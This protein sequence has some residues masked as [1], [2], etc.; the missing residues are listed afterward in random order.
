MSNDATH[1]RGLDG[2]RG[3]AV[4]AVLLFH[5]R[6]EPFS[7]GFLGVSAFFTLSGYLVGS[8]LLA[9]ARSSASTSGGP[10]ASASPGRISLSRFA[11]RRLR[12]LIPAALVAVVL[13]AIVGRALG[14]PVGVSDLRWQAFSS[15][16]GWTN[17]RFL[18]EGKSYAQLFSTP[19][20]FDHFWSL[21]IEVQCY[22]IVAVVVA[23][24]ARFGK[25]RRT[26]SAVALLGVV[27]STAAAVLLFRSGA[28]NARVY[29]GTDTRIAEFLVGVALA[30]ALAPT[31]RRASVKA[32]RWQLDAAGV[33]GVVGLLG[34]WA[35]GTLTSTWVY[36]GGFTLDALVCAVIIYAVVRR[37]PVTSAILGVEPLAWLGRLSYGIYLYHWPVFLVLTPV[38]TG[39]GRPVTVAVAVAVT[40]VMA[41]ASAHWIEG[42]IRRGRIPRGTAKWWRSAPI[43]IAVAMAVVLLLSVVV[44]NNPATAIAGPVRTTGPTGLV[45]APTGAGDDGVFTV[46]AVTDTDGQPEV[47]ALT[48]WAATRPI[49][50][51]DGESWGCPPTA[52][53]AECGTW[54]T[55]WP[56]LVKRTKADLVVMIVSTAEST[57]IAT[58]LGA[59]PPMNDTATRWLTERLAAA[60]KALTKSGTS[61][62][63]LPMPSSDGSDL[64]RR[65][66]LIQGA[67]Y[68]AMTAVFSGSDPSVRSLDVVE[69]YRQQVRAGLDP[70][71]RD[72]A[73]AELAGP[74]LVAIAQSSIAGVRRVMV[75][76]DSVA[77]SVG[78]GLEAW[79][80]DRTDTAVW[81]V[82][83]DGCGV[84]AD[85]DIQSLYAG[86]GPL[87][88]NCLEALAR[89]PRDVADFRPDVVVVLSTIWDLADR[90]LP[91]WGRLRSPGDELFDA[92]MANRYDNTVTQLSAT[93]AH[94]VWL[95]VP[96]TDP[97]A[98]GLPFGV[99]RSKSAFDPR[100]TAHVNATVL[101]ELAAA[102]PDTVRV[103]DLFSI[104][105]PGGKFTSILGGVT[106]ARPDGLHFS[107]AGSR[108]LAD[109]HAADWLGVTP[110]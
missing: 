106:D 32:G 110:G 63:W 93:G 109:T 69:Q 27:A 86:V 103:V 72:S 42:P 87:P 19:S 68:R 10:A 67:F 46:T 96:C 66:D 97:D 41:W 77:R 7:G 83:L 88:P 37:S 53:T 23:L 51:V 62:I 17:W 36:R 47:A 61:V 21:A 39:W 108:W 16:T 76:G 9:E 1:L 34:L 104:V 33:V 11:E 98:G 45:T 57:A 40:F 31:G 2:L 99:P 81:D 28:D 26:L 35:T 55:R 30:A 3:L 70:A 91:T 44:P 50:V 58:G 56:A 85:G 78:V 38:R 5:G 22:V 52:A 60:V 107:A 101:P 75:V 102:H 8:I 25:A 14:A 18:A 64:A 84:W 95:N 90:E 59:S 6:I 12:R 20:A 89:L 80:A 54:A 82:S 43:S 65:T 71:Q 105:C 92:A 48:A 13:C 24:A 29:Y 74:R 79:A 49:K 94:V 100:R 4:A 73:V 15:A